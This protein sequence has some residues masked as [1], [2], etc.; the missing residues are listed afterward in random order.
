VTGVGIS[1]DIT[2]RK[3]AEA[4]LRR[5]N[6]AHRA[7]SSCNQALIRTT[8]ESAWVEHV[9]RIIVEEAG[10]RLCWVGYA[11]QDESRTVRPV[12][13]AGFEEGYLRTVNITW[14]DTERG[15]GP[16]GTCIRTGQTVVLKNLATDP[17]FAPWRAEAVKRGYAS[18]V[19]IPL[20]AEGKTLGALTIYASEPDAFGDEELQLLTELADDLAF[21]VMTLRT[22]AERAAAAAALREQ[23]EHVRLLLDAAAEALCGID[24]RGNCTWANRACARMLGYADPAALLGQNLH[25]LAHHSRPDGTPLPQEE[26]RA[27]RA[28]TRGDYVHVDDE[29]LWRA[30]GTCFPAEYWSHPVRRNGE[31]LG[32]VV[33]FL[34]VTERRR[35]EEGIRTLNAE[36]EQRVASRTADLQ[37]ANRL[38]DEL[39]LREH[40]ASTALEAARGREVEVGFRI[41]QML[42]LD[43]PPV[44]F[45]G[46]RVAALTIPSQTI[47]G[48]FYAFYPHENQHLDVIVADVMGKG[49]PAALLGAATKS[50]FHKALCRL[51]ALPRDGTLPEPREIVT[52]AHAEMG[53]HLLDL[54][55]FVTLCY[56][57]FDPNRRRLDLVDCGHTGLIHWRAATG[58]CEVVHGDNL[59]LGFRQ[60]EIFDQLPVSFEPGDL[61][62]LYSDGVT[63]ARNSSGEFFGEDRLLQG[64]EANSQLGAEGLVEAV[65]QAAVVFAGSKS[66]TDDL[67]CVAVQVVESELPLRRAALEIPS[68]LNEL[69]RARE[70]V[71]AVCG[72]LPGSTMDEE[73][74]G[75]L[76][77]AVTEACSNI[78]RHAYRGR[79]D[80]RIHLEAETFPARVS[81]RLHHLGAAFDPSKV[82]PPTLDGSRTS[83]FGMYLISRSVDE[84]RYYRDE[85]GHNCIALVK[86]FK[87]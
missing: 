38:K 10:Y 16:T 7:L 70:F 45:P 76:E 33:T 54:E 1:H 14:A 68:D 74:V 2:E 26:C 17:T 59:P 12:A 25:S 82:R 21:G 53:H 40:A 36:L 63:E 48:D 85:R 22:R 60:G 19:G 20:A 51:M 55:S 69:S 58:R 32:A 62:V 80:Q 46:L 41:Q 44:E 57:R 87:L 5:S 31:V 61:F 52:L 83:G 66:L 47:D 75:G 81:I 8:D 27:H 64:I 35:A 72:Q 86:A 65:R 29:V 18:A 39:L 24:P 67:T 11:E 84:V 42:L 50:H 6:R 49:I 9:C 78:I 4:A 37:A 79:A 30:D 13:Q 77:L 73:S 15:R 56:V 23:Q 28:L 71:R 34:D 43:Q 3:Q